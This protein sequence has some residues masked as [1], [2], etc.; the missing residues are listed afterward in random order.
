MARSLRHFNIAPRISYDCDRSGFTQ[1]SLICADR[2]GL[3]AA[4]AHTFRECRVRVH[5]A[6]VA[7]FG[8]RA[9][10]Y[11]L[12]SDE[13][14]RPLDAAAREALNAALLDITDINKERH[15]PA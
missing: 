12:I 8:E 13:H 10:D 11:F 14:D 15:A 9:E 1:L 4:V 6:R 7:T 5:D 2:P 3:L